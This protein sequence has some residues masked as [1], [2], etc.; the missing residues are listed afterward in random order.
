MVCG[1]FFCGDKMDK[2]LYTLAPMAGF[3]DSAFRELCL[4]FGAD[5]VTTEM[6]STR[7]LVY[8][9]DNTRELL[10]SNNREGDTFV[11][12][13]GSEPEF[14]YDAV[15]LPQLAKFKGIDIN[16]GCPVP[17]VIKT[18]AGSALLQNI[19]LAREIIKATVRATN[20]PVSVKFRLGWDKDSIVASEFAK[21]CEDAG[22][23]SITIHGRTR[24]EGYSGEANWEIIRKISSEVSIPVFGNGDIQ[25]IEDVRSK[26]Q[27]SNIAGV[28]IGRGALGNPQVFSILKGKEVAISIL[29]II[30]KNYQKM[31]EYLPENRVVP[32]FR[33]QLNFYL[34]RLKVKAEI[35]NLLNRES[36]LINIY[37]IL[38]KIL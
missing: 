12:L 38:E 6:I 1:L 34:K 32:S 31:L 13:F 7:G 8:D 24:E 11:Q 30:K 16:M 15:Q 18:G 4:D 9:S 25:T 20:K 10:F 2:L 19:P 23:K 33:A 17:K 14:F 37:D 21:M 27:D 26:V 29:D 35:R 3:T 28:A 36:S 22:A 5:L